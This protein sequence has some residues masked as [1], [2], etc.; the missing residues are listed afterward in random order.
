M[1]DFNRIFLFFSILSIFASCGGDKSIENVRAL[2]QVSSARVQE[3]DDHR[4]NLE[5]VGYKYNAEYSANSNQMLHSL[6]PNGAQY[7]NELEVLKKHYGKMDLVIASGQALLRD[8]TEDRFIW[9]DRERVRA[10]VDVTL[11]IREDVAYIMDVWK[12]GRANLKRQLNRL[13]ISIDIA[14][15]RADDLDIY[16]AIER[17]SMTLEYYPSPDFNNV[18]NRNGDFSEIESYYFNQSDSLIE[19]RK[20]LANKFNEFITFN[21][22][23]LTRGNKINRDSAEFK[24]S[25]LLQDSLTKFFTATDEYADFFQREKERFEREKAL[26]SSVSAAAE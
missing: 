10:Q 6:K 3:F 22:D 25:Y 9:S 11:K 16:L 7:V 8:Y 20:F 19:L 2:E 24:D 13:K 23:R 4:S 14:E 26:R 17:G 5:D 12:K 18:V 1:N 21:R 15:K